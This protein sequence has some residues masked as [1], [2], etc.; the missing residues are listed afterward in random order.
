MKTVKI[1]IAV[2][3]A[4]LVT[5][6]GNGQTNSKKIAYKSEEIKVLGACSMCKDRIEKA[7]KV[8]G[9]KSAVW[10]QETQLLKVTY[11]P[12]VITNDEIQ[13]RAATVGHDTE[14]YKAD[15]KVYAKLPACCHYERWK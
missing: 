5:V 11:D 7:M 15:D 2:F 4:I 12:A 1:L 3:F 13:K 9:I 6:P 14:K 8:D 10:D